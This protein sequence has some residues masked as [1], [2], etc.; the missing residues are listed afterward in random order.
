MTGLSSV[1]EDHFLDL[2]ELERRFEEVL[3][4]GTPED[5]PIAGYGEIS[6]TFGWPP[7]EP[8]LA[9]KSLPVFPERARLRTYGALVE[10]YVAVLAERGVDVLPT[11]VRWVAAPGGWRGF[12]VQPLLPS[13]SI[14]PR[15]LAGGGSDADHLLGGIVDRAHAA[16]DGRVGLDAQVSNWAAVDGRLLFLDVGTPMLRD[17]AGRDRLDIAILATSVPWILR[18]LTVH[19]VG[20]RLLAPYHDLRATLLDA[21]GNLIRERLER[22]IPRLLEHANERVEPP[23]TG[24]EVRGFYRWNARTYAALQW[25]RRV[26]RAWQRRVR[27]R[28][29]GFLLPGR[30]ER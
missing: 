30:I 12:L 8:R 1:V 16:I 21:A 10:E 20:P 11:E 4:T 29:Y 13:E 17:R 18:G 2:G 15:V 24:R 19:A 27:R 5:L 6:V 7:D 14:G 9:I 25:V 28:P 26:D 3:R 23:L 22:H